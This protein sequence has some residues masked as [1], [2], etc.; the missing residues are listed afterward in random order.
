MPLVGI[1]QTRKQLEDE[2]KALETQASVELKRG[3]NVCLETMMSVTPV[4]TGETV[5]NY[6]VSVGR[7]A[8]GGFRGAVGSEDPGHTNKMPLGV[9]PRRPANEALAR[10]EMV[11]AIAEIGDKLKDVMISN[12]VDDAKWDMIDNGAAPG[13]PPG[14]PLGPN[15]VERSPGGVS[16]VAI[17]TVKS[18]GNWR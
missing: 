4:W 18:S 15:Q 10:A 5:A 16:R 11:A 8:S 3:V 12:S 6:H 13:G 9:E 1:E 7:A 14:Y 17:Q 2:V